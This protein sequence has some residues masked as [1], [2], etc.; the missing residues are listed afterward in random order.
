MGAGFDL[1]LRAAATTL[2]AMPR[3]AVS[4]PS[5]ASQPAIL[6]AAGHPHVIIEA[7]SEGVVFSSL[8]HS[9]GGGDAA[10]AMRPRLP[11][12]QIREAIARAFSHV[13]KPYDFE[14]DFFS[15]DKLVCTELVFRAYDGAIQFPL[16]EVLGRKTM[17]AVE[18][19]RKCCAE[20]GRPQA[21][22]EFVAFLDGDDRRG[23]A[24][25][26]DFRAFE[27]TLKRPGLD[28]LQ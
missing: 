7:V 9:I 21:E 4:L 25:F 6:Q 27:A 1:T 16:V 17:P 12:E 2:P 22:L 5:F 23:T 19:V 14:F 20:H 10:C 13:G 8:E 26:K 3:A 15:T 18:L 11:P 24:S 28:W